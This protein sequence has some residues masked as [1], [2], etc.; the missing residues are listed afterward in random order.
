MNNN[1]NKKKNDIVIVRASESQCTT[2]VHASA[3]KH[4]AHAPTTII[5]YNIIII[6]YYKALTKI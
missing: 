3:F 1:N 4:T 2:A 6:L 5:S